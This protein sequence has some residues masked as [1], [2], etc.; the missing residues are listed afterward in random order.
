M[1]AIVAKKMGTPSPRLSLLC[2]YASQ[3]LQWDL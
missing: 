2:E 3:D 1:T